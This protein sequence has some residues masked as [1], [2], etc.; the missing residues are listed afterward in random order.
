MTNK[1]IM[2]AQK[3]LRKLE[4]TPVKFYREDGEAFWQVTYDNATY[5]NLLDIVSSVANTPIKEQYVY[6]QPVR[7]VA[8]ESVVDYHRDKI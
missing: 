8:Y 4:G 5:I 7:D 2:S 1:Q 3:V 6:S